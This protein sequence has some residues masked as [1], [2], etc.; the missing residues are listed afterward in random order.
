MKLPTRFALFSITAVTFLVAT[1]SAFSAFFLR[2]VFFLL[3]IFFAAFFLVATISA[4]FLVVVFAIATLAAI[5]TLFLHRRLQLL[6]NHATFFVCRASLHLL[7]THL[8]CWF[9]FHCAL[10]II[11]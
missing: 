2:R 10:A 5:A 3:T 7:H 4:F 1:I 11:P 8:L 6:V 9:L